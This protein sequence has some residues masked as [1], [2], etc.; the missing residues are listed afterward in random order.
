[1][2][3]PNDGGELNFRHW[4]TTPAVNRRGYRYHRF[5]IKPSFATIVSD[6]I[7]VFEGDIF[8]NPTVRVTMVPSQHRTNQLSFWASKIA[9]VF[10]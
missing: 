3:R 9:I 8:L 5:G 1:M 2:S 4:I 6:P 10:F 7:S